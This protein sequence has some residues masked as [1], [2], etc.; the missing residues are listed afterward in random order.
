MS[1]QKIVLGMS[2]GV[3]SSVAA[4]LLQQQG[5]QVIGVYLNMLGK[6]AD[7][8]DARAVCE[9]LGI[10]FHALDCQTVFQAQVV[11]R[12]LA[13]QDQGLTPSPCC[14]CNPT[15]KFKYLLDFA[16]QIGAQFVATGHYAQI[17]DG[18]LCRAV[19]LVK[20]QSYFLA[21]LQP[22][23]LKRLVFPLGQLTKPQVREIAAMLG[24]TVHNKPDSSDLC[25]TVSHHPLT[26][27]QRVKQGGQPE[28]M[29]YLG[30]GKVGT[31]DAPELYRQDVVVPQFNFVQPFTQI[32]CTGKVRYRQVDQP[33]T[34]Q[35]QADGRV[36]VHFAEPVRAVTPGQWCVLYQGA[37][38]IGGGAIA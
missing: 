7:C 3:D 6:A 32:T 17:V 2:G 29:Y 24:L 12:Y 18:Q 13:E 27:G 5:Y 26:I 28:K 8:A 25:F 33:C 1:T 36:V 9:H 34:A 37:Q 16:D 31:A 4:H 20:D 38:V 19:Y 14:W 23:Q 22:E 15:V 11:G 30:N 21:G 35:V 10:E